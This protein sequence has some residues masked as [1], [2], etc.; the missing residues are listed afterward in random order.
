MPRSTS[1]ARAER[2]FLALAVVSTAAFTTACDDDPT[3][4]IMVVSGNPS[5]SLTAAIAPTVGR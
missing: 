5:F 2:L 3:A 4:P 1:P